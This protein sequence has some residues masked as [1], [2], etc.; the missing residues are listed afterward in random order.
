M[1]WIVLGA[2]VGSFACIAY[3]V[4]IERHAF[5]LRR[6]RVPILPADARRTVT[7]LHLSDLHCVH[8]DAR[9]ERFVA[10]LP[11]TDLT[12]VTG[13]FLAEAAGVA[14]AI[15]TVRAARGSVAS[16]FV[17]GSN[18]HYVA[19]PMNY[20]RYLKAY[21]H[22]HGKAR[23]ARATLAPTPA[24]IRGLEDDGWI[25]I[26]NAMAS[27]SVEGVDFEVG[28]IDD[29]HIHRDDLA[30]AIR[31]QTERVGLG[32]THSPDPGP[33]LIAMGY[34]L[35]LGGHTHGGQVR[36]P[37]IGA[38]ANNSQLPNRYARGLFRL[39]RGW[40]HISAGLG[41]SKY[42]PFRFLCRP[43]ATILELTPKP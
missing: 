22:E 20:L 28:G 25:D 15:A 29:A 24:L 19:R 40:F 27:C 34:D 38:I 7:L 1:L 21:T 16:Y 9:K 3:G 41:T 6:F 35:V 37:I 12:V 32:V 23:V 18:D 26:D 4:F 17:L 30:T 11:A 8:N 10:S 42:A 36:L 31:H 39:G 43:E 2:A 14:T 5:V 13:D 33:D